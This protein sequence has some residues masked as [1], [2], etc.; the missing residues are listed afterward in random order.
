MTF[1]IP[2]RAFSAA[3][4]GILTIFAG[5]WSGA[6]W[7]Q[8]G[9]DTSSS[10]QIIRDVN[11]SGGALMS[12]SSMR[13]HGTVSQTVI[14]RLR[15]PNGAQHNVG[16]WYWA[17]QNEAYACVGLPLA[18]AEVGTVLTIP[19][20]LEKSNRLPADGTLRYHARI[21]FNGSLLKPV[22][23]TPECTWDGGFC[24]ID[25]EGTITEETLQTGVLAELRF[26]AMLGNSES[27]PLEIESFNWLGAGER[28]I[29]T[30]LKPGQFNLLGV[31]RVDG[32]VR[33]LHAGG[34]SARVRVWPNPAATQLNVEFVSKEEGTARITIVDAIGRDVV[35]LAEQQ[36]D[37][38][39]QYS[40]DF[41]ISSI[42]SG[43]YFLVLR[44]PTQVKTVRLTIQQ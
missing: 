33:L 23:G 21:R 1:G 24:V 31:C 8:S 7:A 34:P 32:Q 2:Q 15:R 5:G 13:M 29:R 43:S 36:V 40:L 12:G 44:T 16:F 22:E 39:T 19:L 35:T 10:F 26:L 9:A 14:G 28:Y 6:L 37:A 3:L 17:Q 41:D 20:L 18:E 42:A 30:E 11:G 4:V 38:V 25:V 27:T